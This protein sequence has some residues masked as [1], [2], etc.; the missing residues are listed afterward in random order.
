[1][2][3]RVSNRGT[4]PLPFGF[5]MHPYFPR[6]S[7]DQET[8]VSLPAEAVMEADETLL[9]TGRI[10]DVRQVMYE[11][12][13]LRQPLPVG[14]LKLDHVYTRLHQ[15]EPALI[16][17]RQQ[18]LQLRIS[19]SDDFTHIV[20]YAPAGAPYFCIEYQTCSTDAINLH[21]QGK[22]ELAHL[23]EVPPA[24]THQGTINYDIKFG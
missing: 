17:Y 22:R 21:Q 14:N 16:D 9:P 13:D 24:G 6:L 10:F 11:M 8:L 12:Y 18:R 19:A 1:L 5:A 23:L 4:G 7:G 3:Y 15:D 2:T 20:I